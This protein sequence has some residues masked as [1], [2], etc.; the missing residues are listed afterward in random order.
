MAR[1]IDA[2][3]LKKTFCA[4]CNHTILCE[5]CDIDFHFEHLAPTVEAI[6]IEWLKQ[7]AE[8]ISPATIEIDIPHNLL[9]FIS[10]R[11]VEVLTE[12]WR[13]DFTPDQI[14]G[15]EWMRRQNDD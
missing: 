11:F 13:R 9:V 5:D 2:E 12:L 1:L 6:P 15:G 7:I 8:K 10:K 14:A 4:E 3:A